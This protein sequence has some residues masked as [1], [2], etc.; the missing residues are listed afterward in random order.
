MKIPS[1]LEMLGRLVATP[2]ISSVSPQFDS[3]NR[4]VIEVLAEW[5]QG[6]GF[7][8]RIL[9][10]EGDARKANLVARLGEGAGGLVLAGHS[11]TVPCDPQRWTSDPFTPRQQDG[12]LYGLGSCDMKSFFASALTAASRLPPERLREPLYLVATA[13]EESTMNGAKQLARLG[14]PRARYA[15][16][17]EPTGLVPI[18]LHK[19]ITM[20]EL[21][22]RGRAGHSSDPALGRSAL[23]G[24]VAAMQGLLDWRKEI[25]AR[26]P[27]NGFD[28]PYPTLNLGRIQGG[29]NPNR[30]CGECLLHFD[31]RSVPPMVWGELREELA[32]RLAGILDRRQLEW[33]LESL[34]V[35]VPPFETAADAPL[36][37]RLETLSGKP[38]RSVAYASEAPF[39]QQLGMETVLLG[40]GEI[41]VAH[42]PDENIAIR[43][44][45]RATD[46]LE[47]LIRH[48]CI[49]LDL[50]PL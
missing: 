33:R 49:D 21:T 34:D 28:V 32:A 13:D 16:V 9:E 22:I 36:V 6:L 30:I 47:G 2:S 4:A 45:E 38:A 7:D 15:V 11:D 17:G 44:V 24:M 10:L 20:Q 29:D 8:V 12:R 48:A 46:L 5:A 19:G 1:T 37:R 14:L 42:R 26:Y 41:G 18:H 43:E 31:L 39:F 25:Q 40:A 50:S 35:E 23:E 27:H 3:G